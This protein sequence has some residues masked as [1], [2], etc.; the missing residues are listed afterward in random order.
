MYFS[1]SCYNKDL[2]PSVHIYIC[3]NLTPSISE[4]ISAN[5]TGS[6]P[7]IHANNNPL[8]ISGLSGLLYFII[9]VKD[10]GSTI[11]CLMFDSDPD[12][13]YIN[14]KYEMLWSFCLLFFLLQCSSP[15]FFPWLLFSN[16]LHVPLF[17]TYWLLCCVDY[18]LNK[19]KS[20]DGGLRL[21]FVW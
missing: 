15:C 1:F 6:T 10:A 18:V 4:I 12:C 14:N 16:L 21:M 7:T 17:I 9:R 13:S 19:R 20:N 5:I 3:T 2:T 8:T 11:S